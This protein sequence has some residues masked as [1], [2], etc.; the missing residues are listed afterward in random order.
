MTSINEDGRLTAKF[1]GGRS[2]LFGSS[3][4]YYAADM[5]TTSEEDVIPF[6]FK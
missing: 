1:K 3:G 2:E 5:G 6:E 4:S